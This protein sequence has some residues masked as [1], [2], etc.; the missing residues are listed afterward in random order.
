M[1]QPDEARRDVLISKALS[2]LLRHGAIKE[3]LTINDQGYIPIP[4]LLTHQRLKSYKTTRQDL[5]R[6]VANNDKQRFKIDHEND[7]IC[8]TQGHSIKQIA[9]ELQLMSRDELKELHIYHGTY[10]KKLLLIQQSGGL[11]RMNRNHIH[12]TCDEYSAISGIRKNANCLVYVDVEK[13]VD[14]G[15]QFYK[16][17]NNV[18]LCSGDE[19]G[20]IGWDLIEKVEDISKEKT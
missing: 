18:I 15:L 19:N 8:A 10:K 20:I 16:S 6:I 7:L 11:S 4:Q 14:Q 3:K 12:F 13:C 2:Y 5:E 1:P 9:G 17:D